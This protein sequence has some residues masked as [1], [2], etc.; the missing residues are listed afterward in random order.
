[1]T[2][3]LVFHGIFGPDDTCLAIS[4]TGNTAAET[5][6]RAE[7]VLAAA[8]G[9]APPGSYVAALCRYHNQP[10]AHCLECPALEAGR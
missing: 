9:W 4:S 10:A 5:W 8:G 2:R 3:P 7:H 1:M 6:A